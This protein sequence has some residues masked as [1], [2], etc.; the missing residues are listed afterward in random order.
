M[1]RIE[2]SPLETLVSVAT[3][4][5]PQAAA[6]ATPWGSTSDSP[7][8]A[9]AGAQAAATPETAAQATSG[10]AAF[11]QQ[12]SG[13]GNGQ[14]QTADASAQGQT[15][16]D[17]AEVRA[18]LEAAQ[19]DLAASLAEE[20]RIKRT[21]EAT[22]DQI[23][24]LSVALEKLEPKPTLTNVIQDYHASQK[25]AL[26]ERADRMIALKATGIDFKKL[27]N[28]K[29]PIDAAM[30]RKTGRGGQRPTNI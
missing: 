23:V 30:S 26:Q 21:V 10:I 18:A 16:Q 15:R 8:A 1:A 19:V 4:Q 25:R 12:T 29:A 28:L 27:L 6:V 14:A 13:V 20:N 11:V 3:T 9:P 24:Q 17:V 22:K 2:K 5:A 7:I